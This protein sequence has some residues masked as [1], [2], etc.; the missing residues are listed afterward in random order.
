M[1][2]PP[3]RF[4]FHPRMSQMVQSSPLAPAAP[5]RVLPAKPQPKIP[6]EPLWHVILL[7]DDDHSYRYV[8]E[9]LGD[10]FAH[11]VEVAW[12][13]AEEVDDTGRVIVATLHKE[14]AEL[15]QQQIHEYKPRSGSGDQD[16]PMRATIEPAE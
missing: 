6:H 13:M 11:S 14:L 3:L 16:G 4:S 12:R 7:N 9:M 8:V 2:I 10:I 1:L 15:R 5:P